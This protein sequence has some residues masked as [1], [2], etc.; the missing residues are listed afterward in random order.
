VL[1]RGEGASGVY[2]AVAAGALGAVIGTL[3][4]SVWRDFCGA[5]GWEW[6]G[7]A[8]EDAAALALTTYAWKG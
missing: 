5:R 7:A 6:Q 8:A 1:A 4:G 3:G 2:P